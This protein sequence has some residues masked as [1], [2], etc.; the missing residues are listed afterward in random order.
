MSLIRRVFS[1]VTLVFAV[2]AFSTF[3]AAQDRPEGPPS[4]KMEGKMGK[5]F[6]ERRGKHKGMHRGGILRSLRR[7]DLT[8]AQRTQIK[9]LMESHRAGFASQHDEIRALMEK[10]RSGTLTEADTA[11]LTEF[12]NQ[13]KASSEQLKNSI[14]ALLTPEQIAKLEQ[15]KAVRIQRMEERK[16]RMEAWRQQRD[17]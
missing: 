7:I 5:S 13:M 10:K 2:A 9:G 4:P 14:T 16:I 17:S 11:R 8:E 6:G 15:M 12:H 1:A 3:V